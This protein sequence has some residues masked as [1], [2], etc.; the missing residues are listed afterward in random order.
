MREIKFRAWID[1]Y[2][3]FADAVEVHSDGS[4]NYDIKVGGNFEYSVNE[5][6]DHLCQYTGLKDKNG[7]EIYE[8]DLIEASNHENPSV[9]KVEFIEGGFCAT[10]PRVEGYPTDINHFYSSVGCCIKVI[11]NIHG[12]PKLLEIKS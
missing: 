7:V 4:W 6:G 10:N 12:I 3:R 5:E 11:G 1:K 9:F 8:G 2:K